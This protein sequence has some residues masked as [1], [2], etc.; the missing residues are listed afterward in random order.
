M[1]PLACTNCNSMRLF[2]NGLRKLVNG[3]KV[4]RW[5]CR[6]CGH[7]F[8]EKKPQNPKLPPQQNLQRRLNSP[9]NIVIDNQ[10]CA[11]K[12]AKKLDNAIETKTIAGEEKAIEQDIKGRL[13]LFEFYCKK[14]GLA[15][16]TTKKFSSII[17]RLTAKSNINDPETVKEALAYWKLAPNTKVLY[18]DAYEKYLQY[19]KLTWD[20]P[21]YK[22]QETTPDFLPTEQELDAIV[23]GS[24]KKVGTMTL[25]MKETGM[26]LGEC[27]S[28]TW[29]NI[30]FE[31]RAIMLPKAEKGSLPRSFSD[32]STMLMNMIGKLPKVN[33]KIF[34]TMT[35]NSA[36]QGL[37]NARKKVSYKLG[38][39]RIAKIHYHLIRHWFGTMEYH[40]KPDPDYIRRLLGH[41]RLSS[42][43]IYINMEKLVFGEGS[44]DYVVKVCSTIEE[45][46][47]LLQVGF[48]YVTDFQGQKVL[49]KRK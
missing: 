31:R 42:T 18:C 9:S 16:N 34:G 10:L 28:L 38:N 27:L 24:G 29:L 39:P 8:T 47:S 30:D 22:T 5:S 33:D 44:K 6:E 17:R 7:R 35:T 45:L 32:R 20:R 13:L 49:R 21:S 23:A 19:M 37:I 43:E 12:E 11:L 14:Q 15:D 2:K 3:E 1:C 48:E 26:R 36:I 46:Q 40:K 25:L 4:Q 41:K